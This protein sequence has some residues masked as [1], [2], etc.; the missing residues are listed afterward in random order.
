MNN[1]YIREIELT[2]FQKHSSL[3]LQF[4]EGVNVIYGPSDAGKSC[5][6]R[7]I[8]FLF[9]GEPHSDSIRKEETKQTSVRAILSSGWEVE[10]V[11]SASINRIILR[12]DGIEK[13][14]D[15]IGSNIPD[16]VKAVLQVRE[17][18]IDKE[19]LNLNIAKQLTLPFLYDKPATFR[20]KLFNMLT[21]NDL[22][23]RILQSYN[24]ELL[25]ISRDTKMEE[26]NISKCEAEL[27]DLK[28]TIEKKKST[29]EQLKIKIEQIKSNY[30]KLQELQQKEE[31]FS[32]IQEQVASCKEDLKKYL[33][34]IDTNKLDEIR[35]KV[36]K[37]GV[38]KSLQD[39]FTAT[40]SNLKGTTEALGGL[41]MISP[42]KLLSARAIVETLAKIK[43]LREALWE[44]GQADADKR[45]ELLN[46]SQ[47]IDSL[48]EKYR[49]LIKQAPICN[50]CGQIINP[51][52][53]VKEI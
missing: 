49:D 13:T 5:I 32:S 53:I 42:E 34:S 8:S 28:V 4:N 47:K 16:E 23:D 48:C 35:K 6:R 45:E 33:K 39:A 27:P 17:L 44:N 18:E 20:A 40:N 43:P 24:K 31:R 11:K 30:K 29:Y 22:I 7:A 36:D 51:D 46:L 21:G 2:N 25:S 26:E 38:L 9:F 10:R 3:K 52:H 19:T 41:R 15:A 50:S 12:K 14:F 1:F 37:I